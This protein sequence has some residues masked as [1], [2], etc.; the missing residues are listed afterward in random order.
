ML[1]R[2][3]QCI[4]LY[5]TWSPNG[6]SL[7]VG[8]FS[9]RRQSDSHFEPDNA[10]DFRAAAFHWTILTALVPFDTLGAD[11]AFFRVRIRDRKVERI[12]SLSDIR[13][14]VGS[15]GPWTGLAP[16]GSPLIQRDVSLDEIYALDWEA[17]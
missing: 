2:V 11:P 9:G 7:A 13:R 12:V 16:D 10:P 17:P 14:S 15:F 4:S 1:I 6:N 5:A 8:G 3:C